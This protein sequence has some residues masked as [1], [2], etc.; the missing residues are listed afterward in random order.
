M[1]INLLY[2][3]FLI[4]SIFAALAAIFYNSLKAAETK[5]NFHV[6]PYGMRK[7]FIDELK[8]T[9]GLA[10]DLFERRLLK[11]KTKDAI[12]IF[13]LGIFLFILIISE[14]L[15]VPFDLNIVFYG[16]FN[17][18][19]FAYL[20]VFLVLYFLVYFPLKFSL[21]IV[22]LEFARISQFIKGKVEKTKDS[23]FDENK[24]ER[25]KI[26]FYH[27]IKYFGFVSAFAI[28]GLFIQ[29]AIIE[30]TPYFY[31]QTN[32]VIAF[33]PLILF[34]IFA[35]IIFLFG[36][37]RLA[38]M[39]D[40]ESLFLIG[41]ELLSETHKAILL[42]TS[43]NGMFSGIPRICY[44]EGI[45]S[46]LKISYKWQNE[47]FISFIKWKH[48]SAFGLQDVKLKEDIEKMLKYKETGS[49]SKF[50]T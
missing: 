29:S 49:D 22:S 2:S 45:G 3:Y 16:Y 17:Y 10:N 48:V 42:K 50:D 25:I 18:Y 27:Y 37:I 13:L 28:F 5:S 32:L 19:Y 33:L 39:Y 4:I 46:K 23:Q 9:Y 35:L 7:L 11:N 38:E 21:K 41:I 12:V 15:L 26:R 8:Q 43:D 24:Y 34:A 40:L 14:A 6:F 30:S 31:Y 20:S 47:K 36:R 44:I 1:N